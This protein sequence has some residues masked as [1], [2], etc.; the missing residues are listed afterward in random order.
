M[1]TQYFGQFLLN[2]GKVTK[3]QLQQAM[4]VQQETRVMLGLLAINH[5]YLNASQVEHVHQTQMSVD[6]RFGEIAIDLGYITEGQLTKLLSSQKNA[7]LVLGQALIN[8]GAFTYEEFSHALEQFKNRHS[9][10]D[11][12][13]TSI[14]DGDVKTL[15]SSTILS[16]HESESEWL[17]D[18]ASLLVKNLIRFV[19]P[20]IKIELVDH[21]EPETYDWIFSQ[22]LL[23]DDHFKN[24]WIAGDFHSMLKLASR[25]AQEQIE[26]ADEMMKASIGEFLN[27]QNGIFLVNMSNQGYDLDIKPQSYQE[28]V[29]KL[30]IP[31]AKTIR[32]I[33]SDFEFYL[34][35]EDL[36]DLFQS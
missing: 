20:N 33:G 6:K 31:N 11:A 2:E 12:Q 5:E 21:N 1:F 4:E 36:S 28:N 25:Y 9:L 22:Q 35:L 27:L 8:S 3:Q 13:F 34:L 24:S 10:S 26:S 17:I 32:V 30:S 29:S 15:I 7:H 18:Y 23:K 14:I 16:D 19:D